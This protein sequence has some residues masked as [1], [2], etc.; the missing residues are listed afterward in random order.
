M[1]YLNRAEKVWIETQEHYNKRSY[2]NRAHIASA[3]GLL[4]LSIPLEKGKN[5]QQSI[6]N[7]RIAYYDNWPTAHWQAIQSAYGN[8]P[9][10]EFY[11]DDLK[12]L[13]QKKHTFLF[14][15]NFEL[16]QF[17]ITQLSIEA[18]IA[19]T[20]TYRKDL[21]VNVKDF[22]T[23]ISPKAKHHFSNDLQFES[24]K[25]AQVFE[26]KHGFLA[27]LSI[28]DALFCMGP[29]TIMHLEASFIQEKSN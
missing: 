24:I 13:Y 25:Y 14:D 22:R 12:R 15:F 27:N 5:E 29:S 6:R 18:N 21:P 2:R 4:R 19:Y 17:F 20:E 1:A 28:L 8:A 11:A 9:F 23:T 7:V 16:I 10:F 3:N 26:E